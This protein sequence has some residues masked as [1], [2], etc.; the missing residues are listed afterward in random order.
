MAR[1]TKAARSEAAR[2][3]NASRVT[4]GNKPWPKGLPRKPDAPRCPCGE[5]TLKR[6][7][8]RRHVC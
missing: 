5:M 1:S 7:L 8:A 4:H 3:L 6:A 2:L